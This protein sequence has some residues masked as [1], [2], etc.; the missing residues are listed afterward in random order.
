MALVYRLFWPK[1]EARKLKF[2]EW[3]CGFFRWSATHIPGTRIQVNNPTGEDF[4]KPAIIICNHQSHLDLLCTLMLSPRIVAVTNQ[5]AWN[6]P[7]YAPVIHY[8]EYYPAADGI[9][10]SE[11]KIRSL[12]E[13][14]YSVL[15]F[16]EGTRSATCEVLRF[17]RGAFYLAQRLGADLLPIYLKGPGRVL[18]KLDFTLHPGD[19]QVEVGERVPAGNTTMGETYQ[20][21]TRAWRHHYVDKIKMMLLVLFGCLTFAVQAQ[22]LTPF[23]AE[24]DQPTTAVIVCPGGSYSWLDW[25]TEG[26]G[27]AQWLQ[28]EGISA[29]V[30]KYPVQG[31]LSF[32]SHYRY[33]FRGHQHPDALH[34]LQ[35][36]IRQVREHA[37]DYNIDPNRLG[38]MGFSAGGHLVASAGEFFTGPE[39]RPDFV[40]PVYPVVTLRDNPW[41]HKRSRRALLGEYR[42][43]KTMWQDSLSLELH[44]RADMPPVFLV[45][46]VDDPIV[47]Y[48]NS[49]ML[50]SA[51]THM[52]I[53]HEY[54]QYK[55]GG[56]GFGAR[57]QKASPESIAWKKEFLRWIRKIHEFRK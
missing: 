15:I 2:H 3:I 29:F 14:G 27:V 55:T 34:A 8:L 33:L 30:L 9:E 38:V 49:E 16:P 12:M 53:P 57:E 23:L 6:F 7:L 22:K 17:H 48:H 13:R 56:H 5:W 51:L 1:D 11:S 20:E 42:K 19:I 4:Q 47:H 50:D 10:A 24:S 45:N 40:V 21:Q 35:S 39:D 31:V 43:R 44:V 28:S 36:A 46:C 18:P 25:D 54:H 26:V 32:W 37:A 41:V 52:D